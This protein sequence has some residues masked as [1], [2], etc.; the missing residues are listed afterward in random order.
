MLSVITYLGTQ[1]VFVSIVES[2]SH[3]KTPELLRGFAATLAERGVAQRILVHDDAI[4]KPDDMSFNN[5]INFLAA[6]RNR[7]MEPLVEDGGYDRVL[8][9]N[10]VYVEPE[11]VI[12][13]LETRNGTYD[14]VCGMDFNHFGCVAASS[15]A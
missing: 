8:F 14:M 13:L 2:N 5:R 4:E 7:A 6:V 12:E 15:P 9:S 1:N 3:D 11:S 10:D